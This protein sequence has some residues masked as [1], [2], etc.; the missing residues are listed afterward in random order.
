[1][2][3]NFDI[4]ELNTEDLANM[5]EFTCQFFKIAT[6]NQIFYWLD[7]GKNNGITTE[8]SLNEVEATI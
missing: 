5:T 1:M 3:K 2:Y 8:K 7:L 6:N 4:G